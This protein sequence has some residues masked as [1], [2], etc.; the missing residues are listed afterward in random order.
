MRRL[1][2]TRIILILSM[3]ALCGRLYY[4]QI[5]SGESLSNQALQQQQISLMYDDTR[6]VIY[7]RNMERLTN[8]DRC[9]YYLIPRRY[10]TEACKKLMALI[11]GKLEGRNG[12]SYLVYKAGTYQ[13]SVN[14]KLRE[15]F[16]A[17]GFSLLSRY[18]KEQ[19]A[20]HVIGYVN[21][22]D[23]IGTSGLEKSYD[24][25][26]RGKDNG[27]HALGSGRGVPL[28]GA[29]IKDSKPDKEGGT[30]LQTTLDKNL[31]SYVE[32]I[33]KEK[34]VSG[35]VVVMDTKTSQILALA[36]SPS[37]DPNAV[38]DYLESDGE[39]LVNHGTQGEYPPGSV[40]KIVVAAAALESGI[41]PEEETFECTGSVEINGVKMVCSGHEK[42]H[43][44]LNLYTAFA[45]SCNCYFAT[46]GKKLGSETILS[47]AKKLG[48]GE[49]TCKELADEAAGNLPKYDE[50]YYSGL[51]NFS[52]GQGSLLTTPIQICQMTNMVA[53]GGVKKPISLVMK[54]STTEA[55][56]EPVMRA[57]TIEELRKMMEL[58]MESGTGSALEFPVPVAGK[59]GSAE[60]TRGSEELVHGWFT[61]FFPSDQPKY[62]VTVFIENGKTGSGSALPVFQQIVNYLY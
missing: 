31:Q 5:A 43:G 22:L 17:Y 30:A 45:K 56:E 36:S 55:E 47:T 11:D 40:F 10:H 52:I 20:A 38:E 12:Q 39:E 2:I 32:T 61:G 34:Q 23:R 46:L 14:K 6:G 8:T 15:E 33:L 18:S 25:Q 60:T 19:I 9:Y 51:A 42:G 29:G 58:V 59:T 16:H 48:L 62:T 28:D 50:R 13:Y 7:D 3:A 57:E 37:F 54:T 21:E 49:G 41:V 4:I 53:N 26:L 27:L 1:Q 35:A 44:K 24:G